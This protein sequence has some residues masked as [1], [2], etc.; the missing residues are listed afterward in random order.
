MRGT[1]K[2]L[3]PNITSVYRRAQ[4]WLSQGQRSTWFAAFWIYAV[5]VGAYLL[6]APRNLLTEHTAFNHYAHLAHAWLNGRLDLADGPPAYAHNNDFAHYRDR[7][8]VAF[9]PFPAVVLLP[10]VAL[11][12]E[13]ELVRDGQIFL[14]LSG[15]APTFLFFALQ[16]LRACGYSSRST[17]TN[18][19]LALS[20]GC[21]SV[22]F[23]TAVQGTVWFAAHVVGTSLAAL[24][25]CCAIE[26]RR[27]FL[28]GLALGLGLLTRPPLAFAA[29]LFAVEAVRMAW[30]R[31][32]ATAP[33]GLWSW[34][35]WRH[36]V[37][38]LDWRKLWV[39]CLWFGIPVGLCLALTYWHNYAR[40]DSPFETGYQYLTVAWQARMKKWG[41]FHYHYLARNLGVLFTMLPWVGD[42]QVP[43]RIN[44][45]GLALWFTTP[46]YLWLLWPKV[47][48]AIHWSLWVTVALVAVPTLFYQNSGWAQF[49]YRFS[50]D[51]AVFLF[52]LLALGGRRFGFWFCLAVVWAIG[53]N[54]FG[55][56]TFERAQYRAF[57][58]WD[59]SQ[60]QF[61]QP[62]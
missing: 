38:S 37:R 17:F 62:D 45:H 50:N 20:F 31:D 30:P 43:F 49:G 23:F 5:T 13:P 36:A 14:W 22:F 1:L 32:A 41:L 3:G 46:M 11:A 56:A 48:P 19:F 10:F 44:V 60:R 18:W 8:F 58:H 33:F 2:T 16:R 54:A 42:G 28:A 9:P 53:V 6:V 29:G 4:T 52:A 40:F 57:Y 26:V 51:Y 39:S 24:Y 34:R 21:G 12:K 15:L 47:K 35:W 61:Y 55:A 25:L 7:W 27:P 59:G